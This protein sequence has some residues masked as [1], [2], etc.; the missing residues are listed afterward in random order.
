MYFFSPVRGIIS[1]VKVCCFLRFCLVLATVPLSHISIA[2]RH[3]MQL[4]ALTALTV[5]TQC[6]GTPAS[7]TTITPSDL[8]QTTSSPIPSPTPKETD[9]CVQRKFLSASF[10][11]E[12]YPGWTNTLLSAAGFL[13]CWEMPMPVEGNP[14]LSSV[15][16]R[17]PDAAKY[18]TLSLGLGCHMMRMETWPTGVC[19]MALVPQGCERGKGFW[20]CLYSGVMKM[21]YRL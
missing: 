3:N 20:Y 21:V 8:V 19:I 16:K 12:R 5:L 18:L 14:K 10:C 15:K 7:A 2:M 11:I 9:I 17:N 4:V 6:E 13:C 1:A